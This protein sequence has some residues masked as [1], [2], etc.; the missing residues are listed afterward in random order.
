MQ[1]LYGPNAGQANTSRFNLPEFN[2]LFDEARR[3]PDPRL[4]ERSCSTGWR[5][6]SLLT[7]RGGSRSTRLP[8]RSRTAGS[9]FSF[10]I[11]CAFR[12]GSPTST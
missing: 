12:E 4:N 2:R 11:R 5:N 9:R 8:I 7:C 6:S 3:L 1:L 10:H